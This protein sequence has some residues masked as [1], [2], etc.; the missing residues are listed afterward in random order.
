MPKLDINK[1]KKSGIVSFKTKAEM[2]KYIKKVGFEHRD[3]L[4]I[5]R[6]YG[7]WFVRWK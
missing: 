4:E 3:S 6:Y 2:L 7:K 5:T 1:L